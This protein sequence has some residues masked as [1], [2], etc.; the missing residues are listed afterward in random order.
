MWELVERSKEVSPNEL[1]AARKEWRGV[2]GMLDDCLEEV[3]EMELSSPGTEE[4]EDEDEDDF[5]S[6]HPLSPTELARVSAV[7][8]LLRLGRLLL[9]RLI[10]STALLSSSS[11]S[12]KF[13]LETLEPLV[14][15]L[16]SSADDLALSLEPPQEDLEECVEEWLEVVREL[17]DQLEQGATFEGEGEGNAEGK[18]LAVWR[19]QVEVAEG[20]LGSVGG[21]EE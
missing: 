11:S 12:H 4:E 3:K 10:N 7:H 19:K 15:Q 6:S 13:P 8:L 17:A 9:N 14:H 2:L 16:S 21:V 18:W 5:R 20:K 1:A